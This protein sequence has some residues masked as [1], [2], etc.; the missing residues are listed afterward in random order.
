MMTYSI[1]DNVH[2]S[3]DE[4][5]KRL[6]EC[7]NRENGSKVYNKY[8]KRKGEKKLKKIVYYVQNK[9]YVMITDFF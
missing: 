2:Y 1:I 3:F 5:Y 9:N 4:E 8:K 6:C 7:S